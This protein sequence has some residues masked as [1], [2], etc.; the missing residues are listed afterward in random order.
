MKVW[1]TVIRGNMALSGIGLMTLVHK[2]FDSRANLFMRKV[3]NVILS[4]SLTKTAMM[5]FPK[6]LMMFQVIDYI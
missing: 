3:L 6:K 5:A 4:V 1:F 2:A